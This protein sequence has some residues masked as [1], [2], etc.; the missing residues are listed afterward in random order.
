MDPQWVSNRE[1]TIANIDYCLLLFTSP[2][3]KLT[4]NFLCVITGASVH[5]LVVHADPA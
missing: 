5:M 4:S 3:L 1:A 2:E